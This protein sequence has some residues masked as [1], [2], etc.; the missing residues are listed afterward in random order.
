QLVHVVEGVDGDAK[1]AD[2]AGG[3]RVVAVEAHEGGQVEGGAQT[4]LALFEQ[5]LETLV[6]LPGR[7]EAGELPHGP[8]PAA[9]HGGVDAAGVRVLAGEAE[10]RV[11]VKAVEAFGGVQGVDGDPANGGGRLLARGGSG[12]FLLPAFAGGGVGDG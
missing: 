3:A 8:Q 2:L 4:G 11:G 12:G 6:G 9:V 7:A 1:S 10:F 5:E